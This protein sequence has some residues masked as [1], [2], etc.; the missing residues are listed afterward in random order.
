MLYLDYLHLGDN[1]FRTRQS[2]T[3]QELSS[4]THRTLAV[5]TWLLGTILF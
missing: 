3:A 5:V 2:G 4:G 1:Q